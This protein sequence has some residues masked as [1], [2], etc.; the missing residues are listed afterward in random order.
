MTDI[1]LASD[2]ASWPTTIEDLLEEQSNASEVIILQHYAL[3]GRKISMHEVY[4]HRLAHPSGRGTLDV[5][6]SVAR[7]EAPVSHL[8]VDYK[9]IYDDIE[10]RNGF[11]EIMMYGQAALGEATLANDKLEGL[12]DRLVQYV[13]DLRY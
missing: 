2:I 1:D 7:L 8:T 9:D 10:A 6:R 5:I 11:L 12:I 13:G 4:G 3:L